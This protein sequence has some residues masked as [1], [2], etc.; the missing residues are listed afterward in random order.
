MRYEQIKDRTYGE[1]KPRPRYGFDIDGVLCDLMTPIRTLLVDEYGITVDWPTGHPPTWSVREWGLPSDLVDE[2]Q[3]VYR[4]SEFFAAAPPIDGAL[5]VFQAYRERGD[6][7]IITSRYPVIAD[8]TVAW[9]RAHGFTAARLHM[10][11]R[12]KASLIQQLGLDM[13][14]EDAPHHLWAISEACPDVTL[15]RPDYSYNVGLP[16]WA[17][18][19]IRD[20]LLEVRA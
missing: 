17:Y 15:F 8:V 10:G 11:V 4:T 6:V 18:A 19:D 16:G 2:V 14:W 9:L 7:H 1:L 3:A 12:D 13:Y 20:T 5:E